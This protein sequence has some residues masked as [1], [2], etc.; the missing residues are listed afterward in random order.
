[1]LSL[2]NGFHGGH[3]ESVLQETHSSSP[4]L[5]I[6]TF[7]AENYVSGL[8]AD[9]KRDLLNHELDKSGFDNHKP[10]KFWDFIQKV[11]SHIADQ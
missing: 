2:N 1:M 6:N 7:Y 5:K 8:A 4:V 3:Q 9:Q 10:L 11:K